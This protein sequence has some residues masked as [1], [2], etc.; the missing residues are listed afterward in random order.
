MNYFF[1]K[2]II[3]LQLVTTHALKLVTLFLGRLITLS[4]LRPP[5]K[6]SAGI[7]VESLKNKK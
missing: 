7:A 4:H 3:D 1:V 5:F 2:I 6:K